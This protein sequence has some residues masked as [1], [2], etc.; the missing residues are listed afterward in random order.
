MAENEAPLA[1][2][3]I[4]RHDGETVPGGVFPNGNVLG[5]PESD[6]ADVN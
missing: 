3:G 2:V 4:L 6:F 5:L 1:E